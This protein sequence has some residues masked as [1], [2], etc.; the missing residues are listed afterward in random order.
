MSDSIP[1]RAGWLLLW[2]LLGCME[3]PTVPADD[4]SSSAGSRS[5]APAVAGSAASAGGAGRAAA[6]AAGSRAAA[7]ASAPV[8]TQPNVPPATPQ[9]GSSA[10]AGTSPRDVPPACSE[11][12][13]CCVRITDTRERQT[14]NN[15][16]DGADANSCSTAAATYCDVVPPDAGTTPPNPTNP[17]SP[18]NPQQPQTPPTAATCVELADCC[19]LLTDEDQKQDCQRVVDDDDDRDCERAQEEHCASTTPP[20]TTPTTPP[21]PT[22]GACAE[23]ASACCSTVSDEGDREDCDED[24]T[25]G[26]AER[27]ISRHDRLCPGTRTLPEP[28]AAACVSLGMC[29]SGLPDQEDAFDCQLIA[30][31][32]DD[33]E[34]EEANE[35]LCGN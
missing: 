18:T 23:L 6:G 9:A 7:G 22:D 20:P 31:E 24:V 16:A 35:D 19:G 12:S 26:D 4:A 28:T 25:E 1:R 21:T 10:D 29:C 27:C 15:T 14:C 30:S 17:T 3:P 5:P 34:C 2:P 32:D 11:L 8:Q 33:R 13:V